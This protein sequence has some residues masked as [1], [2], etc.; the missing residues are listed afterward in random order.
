MGMGNRY[1]YVNNN[2]ILLVDPSGHKACIEVDAN[3]NC[4]VYESPSGEIIISDDFDPN[5]AP[6]LPYDGNSP[7]IPYKP[8]AAGPDTD[9]ST[10]L[11][12]QALEEILGRPVTYDELFIMAAVSEGYIFRDTLDSQGKGLT[13]GPFILEGSVRLFY[14][15]G[16][17]LDGYELI[18]HLGILEPFSGRKNQDHSDPQLAYDRAVYLQK[19]LNQYQNDTDMK[20]WVENFKKPPGNW[21]AGWL[22][23]RVWNWFNE[24]T[25]RKIGSGRDEVLWTGNPGGNPFTVY[26]WCQHYSQDS[27]CQ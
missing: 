19:R 9:L 17:L 8:L 23:D 25:N 2:P 27:A 11:T 20:N 3:G 1:W 26:T 22:K 14:S 6:E 10:W 5:P 4:V 7:Y 24:P 12:L 15:N 13:L 16:K 21:S 18:N